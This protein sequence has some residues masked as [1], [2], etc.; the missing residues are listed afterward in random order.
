MVIQL[1]QQ[2]NNIEKEIIS[3]ILCAGKGTRIAQKYTSIPKTLI[4]VKN[5]DD[6]PILE[7]LL[8]RLNKIANI[9]QNWIVI[10][11]LGP[12][13]K[14]YINSLI[15]HDK[16]TK[17]KIRVINAI[18]DYEKGPLYSLLSV[19]S[20]KGI[21]SNQSYLIIPGDTIFEIE[22]LLEASKI[23]KNH[24]SKRPLIFYQALNDTEFKKKIKSAKTVRIIETSTKY[25]N[26]NS[27]EIL[28]KFYDKIK[29]SDLNIR[30]FK[31]VVPIFALDYDFLLLLA[32]L[33]PKLNTNTIYE[34][35]NVIKKDYQIQAYKIETSGKF[36]DIDTE[37]DLK[38]LNKKKSGQ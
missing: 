35:L 7:I 20:T 8:D 12:K 24:N 26:S 11:Y 4:K 32:N 19:L 16:I 37:T 14:S 17:N 2:K 34:A 9:N 28:N 15:S 3:I 25:E 31:Q 5:F 18:E 30:T 29:I 33:A 6:K 10:G 23:I 21:N 13:I 1:L 27:I 38:N 36:F 22:I